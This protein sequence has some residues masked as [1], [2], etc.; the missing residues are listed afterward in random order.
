MYNSSLFGG[1]SMNKDKKIIEL[2]KFF[3][4]KGLKKTACIGLA[5]F[6]LLNT[7]CLSTS[8]KKSNNIGKETKKIF[9]SKVMPLSYAYED[10]EEKVSS[11]SITNEEK[12]A[13]ICQKENITQEQFAEIV[14]TVIGEAAANSYDDAYAVINTFYNRKISKRWINEVLRVTGI[15]NGDNL[16]AQITLINQSSVYTSGAYKLYL[17][18]TD[19]PAYQAVIDF[20]YTLE[21]MHDYLCFYASFGNIPDSEQFA[22]NGNWYYSLMPSED[23]VEELALV[24]E[25]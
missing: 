16:Y 1:E 20:L 9:S 6:I 25:K 5:L 18:I 12:I 2:L 10:Y 24:R 13:E 4:E 15:D 19:V 8:D 22:E 23:R 11:P 21:P 3:K 14:A 17:G 7:S